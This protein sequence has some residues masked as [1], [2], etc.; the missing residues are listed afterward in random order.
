MEQQNAAVKAVRLENFAYKEWLS[1]LS[2]HLLRRYPGAIFHYQRP[3][4]AIALL[5]TPKPWGED[6]ETFFAE[7][8][9]RAFFQRW[10]PLTEVPPSPKANSTVYED[11]GYRIGSGTRLTLAQQEVLFSQLG[12]LELRAQT[13]EKEATARGN[14]AEFLE[15][16]LKRLTLRHN[17]LVQLLETVNTL[18][19]IT[20]N[21]DFEGNCEVIDSITGQ[22]LFRDTPFAEVYPSLFQRRG[23]G[24]H[25]NDSE[26]GAT[27]A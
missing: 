2:Q 8:K 19:Q 26:E 11:I 25:L 13:A 23:I 17:Y 14:H 27:D 24:R 12:D 21:G 18:F 10:E 16:A 7:L 9:T 3:S 4:V 1:A 5:N 15:E 22:V 20:V 6:D